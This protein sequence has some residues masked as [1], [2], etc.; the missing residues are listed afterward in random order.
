MKKWLLIW[1]PFF[2]LFIIL[3]Y[4]VEYFNIEII[5]DTDDWLK[6]IGTWAI[7]AGIAFLA[8]DLFLPIPSSMVMIVNGVLFGF[9]WGGLISFIGSMLAAVIGFWL[10]RRYGIK[11]FTKLVGKAEMKEMN[12]Y[13][14]KV[15]P[16]GIILSRPVPML[17]EA[18]SCMA[19]LT[20]MKTWKFLLATMLG[21][22]PICF[23]YSYA[24]NT[25]AEIENL[26]PAFLICIFIPVIGWMIMRVARKTKGDETN[27]EISL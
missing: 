16:Y 4:I 14:E 23:I 5:K 27:V 20:K 12:R 8:L 18:V 26:I 15:G 22:L 9:W 7:I 2:I 6:T 25:S 3:F 10:C 24:G 19:G 1:I 13:F 17:A 21:T 11:V